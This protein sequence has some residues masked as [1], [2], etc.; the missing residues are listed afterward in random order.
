MSIVTVGQFFVQGATL[1][2]IDIGAKTAAEKYA[3]AQVA[4]K[5]AAAL[6]AVASGDVTGALATA[7]AALL[8][9]VTDPGEVALVNGLFAIAGPQL[10]VAAQAESVIPFLAETLE[11]VAAEAATG[12]TVIASAYKAPAAS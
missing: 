3:R 10:Q 1:A 2:G 11:G 7:Q 4:L 8:T 6:S 12:I 5:V 9:K